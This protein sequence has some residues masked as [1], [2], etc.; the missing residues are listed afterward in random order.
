MSKTTSRTSH[1]RPGK[2]NSEQVF[3]A[4]RDEAD[5]RISSMRIKI[6]RTKEIKRRIENIYMALNEAVIALTDKET[7]AQQM[8]NEAAEFSEKATS[9]SSDIRSKST[10]EKSE[11]KEK[12]RV[13]ERK[14]GKSLEQ[15]K[16]EKKSFVSDAEK[17]FQFGKNPYDRPR[18]QR[19]VAMDKAIITCLEHCLYLLEH[20]PSVDLCRRAAETL[21][22]YI[23]GLAELCTEYDNINVP[24]L[25]SKKAGLEKTVKGKTGRKESKNEV[26][27]EDET[28]QM[29]QIAEEVKSKNGSLRSQEDGLNAPL[30]SMASLRAQAESDQ[31]TRRE[32][33]A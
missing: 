14:F 8:D 15:F 13:A 23:D 2:V 27:C 19:D 4:T 20:E 29:E 6:G 5:I 9:S 31:S 32:K 24:R 7:A 1:S 3:E 21:R 25:E 12:Q 17:N 26:Q 16:K 18:N 30:E 28:Q 22:L 33:G 10:R 11:A